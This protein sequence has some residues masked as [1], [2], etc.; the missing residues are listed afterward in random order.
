VLAHDHDAVPADQGHGAVRP[1]RQPGEQRVEI[2]E[3]DR[4]QRDAGK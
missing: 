3:I 2:L 1:K 4:D